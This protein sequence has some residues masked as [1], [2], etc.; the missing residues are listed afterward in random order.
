MIISASSASRD[1]NVSTSRQHCSGDRA[2]RIGQQG[3]LGL[4]LD[5]GRC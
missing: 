5:H 3:D 2:L 4:D 1:T